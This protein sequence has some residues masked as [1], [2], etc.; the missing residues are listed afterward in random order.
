MQ[1]MLTST[2]PRNSTQTEMKCGFYFLTILAVDRTYVVAKWKKPN[3]K[4]NICL[5]LSIRSIFRT[6]NISF[7]ND[8]WVIEIKESIILHLR[9]EKGKM[10][11]SWTSAK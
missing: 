7:S 2:G 6:K 1:R 10:Q 3:I 5:Q 8:D 9:L 11:I 4:L